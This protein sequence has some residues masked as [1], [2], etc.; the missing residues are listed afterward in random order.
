MHPKKKSWPEITFASL[1]QEEACRGRT[2]EGNEKMHKIMDN[3]KIKYEKIENANY[4]AFAAFIYFISL[5]K[6]HSK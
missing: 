6:H 5:A 3:Q 2:A 1:L 4:Q